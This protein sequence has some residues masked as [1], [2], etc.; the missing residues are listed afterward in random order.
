MKILIA[1]DS[2]GKGEY[3]FDY[4]RKNNGDRILEETN[5]LILDHHWGQTGHEVLSEKFYN[6]IINV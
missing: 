2:W 3:D 1:G 4:V 6:R 5:N